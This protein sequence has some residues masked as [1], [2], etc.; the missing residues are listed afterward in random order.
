MII[1][2]VFFKMVWETFELKN[3]MIFQYIKIYIEYVGEF[4]YRKQTKYT[5]YSLYTEITIY[6]YTYI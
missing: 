5:Y 3:T 2:N 1:N 4:I 6:I